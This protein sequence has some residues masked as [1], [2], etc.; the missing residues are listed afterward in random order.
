M[1][2]S[3]N[4]A[5]LYKDFGSSFCG[6]CFTFVA[7]LFNV[8]FHEAL[9]IIANDFNILKSDKFEQ[10]KPEIKYTYTKFKENKDTEIQVEIR[11][12]QNYEL[13]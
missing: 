6:D 11:D 2:R 5:L 9:L 10:H 7:A 13:A 1:Y 12:F 8:S 4:G 3:K